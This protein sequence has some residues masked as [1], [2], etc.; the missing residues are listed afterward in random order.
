[1]NRTNKK[2]LEELARTVAREKYPNVPDHALA[3]QQFKDNSTNG[4]TRCVVDFINLSGYQAERISTTGRYIDGT[5]KF[6]DVLGQTRTIGSGKYIP[7]TGT[8]GSAD[9]SATI[10]GR[11]VKIEIKFGKDRQSEAQKKYQAAIEK[12]GGIYIIVR[13]MDP[14]LEWYDNFVANSL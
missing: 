2:R 3:I 12:A 14:F 8:K 5:S 10:R 1:M 4:L 7:G 13:E 11:S 6:T 9:I